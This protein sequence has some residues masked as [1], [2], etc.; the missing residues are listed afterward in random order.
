MA[1]VIVMMK[2]GAAWV[3]G[4]RRPRPPE[5]S[6]S[7]LMRIAESGVD[8]WSRMEVRKVDVI[9]SMSDVRGPFHSS[10]FGL[11]SLIGRLCRMS[12]DKRCGS[13][14]RRHWENSLSLVCSLVME[15]DRVE[16]QSLMAETREEKNSF[17]NMGE[18]TG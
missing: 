13:F 5:A 9:S 17:A 18:P 4:Q 6:P 15:V 10:H 16:R 3:R 14:C 7:W 12:D 2:P 1:V 11:G 8:G